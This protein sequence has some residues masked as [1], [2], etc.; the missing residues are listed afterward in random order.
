MHQQLWGYKVEEKTYLGVRERKCLN[1]TSLGHRVELFTNA[2]SAQHSEAR[3]V[4][5]Y[6]ERLG[7]TEGVQRVFENRKISGPARVEVTGD[8]RNCITRSFM[9]FALR[10][11]LFG[12]R[13]RGRDAN[14]RRH[15][16]ESKHAGFWWGT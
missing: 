3:R 13:Y 7:K 5:S 8:W 1:I 15:L 4:I 9:I 10:Q 16:R 11:M 6:F 14:G 2:I 12:L